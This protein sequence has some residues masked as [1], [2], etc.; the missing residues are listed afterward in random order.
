MWGRDHSQINWVVKAVDHFQIGT[1][2]VI[3]SPAKTL[4]YTPQRLVTKKSTPGFLND[5]EELVGVARKLSAVALSE[6]MGISPKL[7]EVNHQ[8]FQ[9]WQ[10]PFPKG[11]AK[12]ALLAFKGDVY[13]GFDLESFRASDWAFAQ[14]HLRILSGLY[15]LLRPLDMMLPYRLEMGTKLKTKRGKDLYTFWGDTITDSLN[16][17]LGKQGDR[18]LINL[19]SNEYFGAVNRE[20]FKGQIVTPVFKDTKNGKVKIISFYAKKARG[21]MADFLIREKLTKIDDLKAFTTG[22]Y[23][24]EDS[25]STESELVF[26]RGEL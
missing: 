24:F 8:R 6:L 17:A 23:G 22:G 4:D 10:R 1:M 19:A 5:S 21:M 9:D 20:A 16:R 3:L 25:L 11:Q 13:Q 14:D 2:L 7:A 18:V 15:G 26:S 12:Q